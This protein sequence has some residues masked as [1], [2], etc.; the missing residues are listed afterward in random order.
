MLH[1]IVGGLCQLLN[2]SCFQNHHP[3]KI[4]FFILIQGRRS[5]TSNNVTE[6]SGIKKFDDCT[7]TVIQ[8]YIPYHLRI[9]PMSVT[10]WAPFV[11]QR[12]EIFFSCG[13][14]QT[15]HHKF[16]QRHVSTTHVILSWS[17]V[18]MLIYIYLTPHHSQSYIRRETIVWPHSARDHRRSYRS[19]CSFI[20]NKHRVAYRRSRPYP[21]QFPLPQ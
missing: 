10:F 4:V 21:S 13:R 9:D 12:V 8:I 6:V 15:L 1:T 2:S 19:A 7:R 14:L 11:L 5:M 16:Q 3:T 20:P 18:D 17:N